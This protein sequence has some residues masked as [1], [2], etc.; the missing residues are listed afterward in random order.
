VRGYDTHAKCK[1]P[2]ASDEDHDAVIAG[3]LDDTLDAIATDHAPHTVIEKDL[4]FGEAPFGLIGMETALGVLISSLIVP[5]VLTLPH[6]ISKLTSGPAGVLGVE[7]GSLAEGADADIT[8]FDAE[9]SWTVD[10]EKFHS[11]SRNCPWDGQELI[12]QVTETLVGGRIVFD[13]GN[14]LV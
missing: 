3:L 5:G 14:I 12:G 4:V 11:A 2:I 1:P 7:K 8:I 6:L 10:V 9:R 13:N